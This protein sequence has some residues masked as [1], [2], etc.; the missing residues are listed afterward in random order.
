MKSILLLLALLLP[1]PFQSPA[2]PPRVVLVPIVGEIG[3]MNMTLVRRAVREIKAAPPAL[4]VFEIDT[5]GG[6]IDHM[7]T[8]G[9]EIQGLAPIPTVA[10]VRPMGQGGMTGGAWSAGAFLA[11]CC[12]KLYMSP[13][14]VI[15]AAA[16][17]TETSEGVK[18]VEE[19]YVSAMRE[20]FRA[21]AEQNGYPPNLMV[22]MVDRDLEVFEVVID[23]KRLYPTLGEME[24][25]KAQGKV[26]E[27]PKTPF[28]P[29]GKLLTLTDRQVVEAGMGWIA[30]SRSP[31]YEDARISSPV[32]ITIAPSWSEHLADFVT[33][34]I[35]STLLLVAGLLGIWIELKTPGFGVAGIVGILAFALLF[36]GHHLAGLAQAPEI[37]LFALGVVLVIVEL[38]WFPGVAV[39][40]IAGVLCALIGLVMSLQGFALP[41][42]KG[43]PWQIDVLLGSVGRVL[44]AFV[45][46]GVGLVSFLR[47]LPKVPLFGRLVLQTQLAGTAPAPQPDVPALAGRQGHAIT[48]LRPSGK[49]EID[50]QVLDVVAEGEFVAQGEPVEILRSEGIRIVVGRA[51][52]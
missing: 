28:N 34:G 8:M 11:I 39:F 36:F 7:L 15:G 13:G 45:T 43:A 49:V 27:W 33:S 42:T 21:R 3:F 22:A 47:F 4:V 25:L 18:P 31:I 19:K 52:R 37:L 12:K 50:G 35:V 40:A 41:D 2:G 20:K 10:Y 48:P 51:K 29:K 14:T 46:A 17:V 6:R 38:V 32:E 30:E 1:A 16:P 44:V 26:F 23:G 24:K 9:E 5:P